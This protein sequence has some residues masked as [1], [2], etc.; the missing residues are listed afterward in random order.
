MGCDPNHIDLSPKLLHDLAGAGVDQVDDGQWSFGSAPASP[1]EKPKPKP[2]PTPTTHY[3]PPPPPPTTTTQQQHTTSTSSHSSSSTHTSSS[4]SS[5]SATSSSSTSSAV[6]SAT[7]VL[8]DG[9]VHNFLDLNTLINNFGGI[10]KAAVFV[11][12]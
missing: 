10:A 3:T 9:Q 4:K 11:Q 12:A 1:P 2:T 6:P 5:A 7:P 8:D